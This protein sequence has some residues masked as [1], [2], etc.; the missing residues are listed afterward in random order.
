M[1]DICIID[2]TAEPAMKLSERHTRLA[3]L[4]S[5]NGVTIYNLIQDG[6]PDSLRFAVKG[7][8]VEHAVETIE[9]EFS[10]NSRPA[11]LRV[12]R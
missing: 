6:S 11:Y 2:L 1:K 9:N 8:E 12:P 3:S 7:A 5:R 4:L 10:P